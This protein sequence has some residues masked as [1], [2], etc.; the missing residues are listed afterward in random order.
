MNKVIAGLLATTLSASFAV[1]VAMPA[2]A[3]QSYMPMAATVSSGTQTVDYKPWMKHR[4]FRGNRNF[5]RGD[6]GA[7]WNGHRG[8]REYRHGYRRHGDFW[9]P[10]AAFATGALITGA[11]V[12]SENNRVYE[13]NAHVQW[14]YDHYRSYRASD[15]TFQ[16]NYGPRKECRSP[17]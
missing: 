10:L 4:N 14:C 12:N 7:Y 11:I 15:N 5:N 8:Y 13:G 2:D 16:P 3:A 17:Y 6:D 9:F 1:A